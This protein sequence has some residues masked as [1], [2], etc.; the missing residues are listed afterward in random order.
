[1]SNTDSECRGE[2]FVINGKKI[3]TDKFDNSILLSGISFY[4]TDVLPVITRKYVL[5]LCRD[6]GIDIKE[7]RIRYSETGSYD[8]CFI[9][10]TSPGVLAASRIGSQMYNTA[11]PLLQKVSR[12]YEKLVSKYMEAK[13]IQYNL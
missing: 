2:I 4:S 12:D 3:Q 10:G 13:K 8:S 1:M 11:H 9:R 5:H 6:S 7:E